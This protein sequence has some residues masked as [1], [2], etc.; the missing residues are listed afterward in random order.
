MTEANKAKL[1][2][3]SESILSDI[4]ELKEYANKT[5]SC[6][7]ESGKYESRKQKLITSVNMAIS[8][9]RAGEFLSLLK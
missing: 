6:E 2:I 7:H 1:M 9:I 4:K 5:E 3:D 8:S